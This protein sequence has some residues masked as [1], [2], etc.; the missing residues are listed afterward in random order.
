MWVRRL[1]TQ[2]TTSVARARAVTGV[3]SLRTQCTHTQGQTQGHTQTPYRA[4]RMNTSSLSSLVEHVKHKTPQWSAAI[5]NDPQYT[6]F[7]AEYRLTPPY[8]V[9]TFIGRTLQRD[10]GIKW[11]I[12]FKRNE[13]KENLIEIKVLMEVGS[14]VNGHTNIA[15][16]GFVC[17]II[18]EVMGIANVQQHGEPT[19]TAYLNVTFKKPTPTPGILMI[20]CWITKAEGRKRFTFAS[21]EDGSGNVFATAEALFLVIKAAL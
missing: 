7:P 21:L 16:G 3:Y 8:T 6:P 17:T 19:L 2:L 20:R 12:G 11:W 1:A 5:A 18:D 13:C 10:T 9:D 14:G 15:H 4:D